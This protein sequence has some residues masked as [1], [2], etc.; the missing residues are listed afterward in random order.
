MAEL[1][2]TETE[3]KKFVLSWQDSL[4]IQH[5]LDVIS[6]IVAEEYI[7]VAK[8]NPELFTKQGGCK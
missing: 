7:Q 4:P 1:Q 5:L 2:L 3:Q 6:T 8:E